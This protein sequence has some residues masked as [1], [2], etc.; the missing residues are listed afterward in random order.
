MVP[1]EK[2]PIGNYKQHRLLLKYHKAAQKNSLKTTF[3]RI[4]SSF[5][6]VTFTSLSMGRR[7][8]NSW[9]SGLLRHMKQ[10][11]IEGQLCSLSSCTMCVRRSI[12]SFFSHI[13]ESL[14]PCPFEQLEGKKPWRASMFFGSLDSA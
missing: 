2:S 4:F 12:C 7:R 14:L 9:H 11:H 3:N 10:A 1:G 8:N 6:W 13:K 5:I